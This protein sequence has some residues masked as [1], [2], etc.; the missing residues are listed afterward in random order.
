MEARDLNSIY[1]S[2]E[3]ITPSDS[4]A[5][6]GGP[7]KALYIGTAGAGTLKVTTIDGSVLSFAG[8]TVG[9]FPISVKLVWSTGTGAS[10]IVG[11]R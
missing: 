4:V 11:L 9:I 10:N 8:V 3:A 1:R 2:G 6:P 7:V 5:I